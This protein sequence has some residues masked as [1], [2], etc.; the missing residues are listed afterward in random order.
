M[1]K[2]KLNHNWNGVEV[3]IDIVGDFKV[4]GFASCRCHSGVI[5]GQYDEIPRD[6]LRASSPS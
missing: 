3:T 4:G 5:T 1:V 2:W 6:F